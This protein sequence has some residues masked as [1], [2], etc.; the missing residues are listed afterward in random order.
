MSYF[1]FFVGLIPPTAIGQ[2]FSL[3]LEKLN[4]DI[5]FVPTMTKFFGR[6]PRIFSNFSE[7]IG[8]ISKMFVPLYSSFQGY[9]ICK[10]NFNSKFCYIRHRSTI[11]PIQILA[12]WPCKC[13]PSMLLYMR[14]SGFAVEGKVFLA[15]YL[16]RFPSIR[17]SP[18]VSLKRC[19]SA[20][21]A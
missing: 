17:Q 6:F 13:K 3:V 9:L 1:Y 16:G 15:P 19:F 18:C 11:L 4:I 21:T 2:F 8:P 7:S 5:S 10:T 20:S 14:Q 12:S